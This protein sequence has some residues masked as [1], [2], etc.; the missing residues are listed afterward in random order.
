MPLQGELSPRSNRGVG[1]GNM[2]GMSG[3]TGGTGGG[4]QNSE[5]FSSFSADPSKL[6]DQE[7]DCL[8][9]AFSLFDAD[10]DGEITINELGRV[11]RNHGLNPTDDE[12]RDMIRNV[13]KNS[14]GAIDFNEFI[15][16]MLRRDSKIEEDVLHAFR[17][18]DRD[19][20]GLIS[21]EELKL[22]MNN[23]GEPLTDHEVKSMIE[24]ADIDGDGRINFQEFS[25]L[26]QQGGIGGSDGVGFGGSSHR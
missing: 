6:N 8:K 9:E 16:M 17:V 19:G 25:R 26:M 22:T 20:D 14:N 11:M 3:P 23:L 4:L 24:A 2:A 18:F 21:A 15:E 12:L 5:S 1:S 7:L 13:D 10:H